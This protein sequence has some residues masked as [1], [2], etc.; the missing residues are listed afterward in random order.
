MVSYE[1]IIKVE[2]SFILH[3]HKTNL[4]LPKPLFRQHFGVTFFHFDLSIWNLSQNL[5]ILSMI[6]HFFC[7]PKVDFYT[8]SKYNL[9]QTYHGTHGSHVSF[10]SQPPALTSPMGSK[11]GSWKLRN[12]GRIKEPRCRFWCVS[13]KEAQNRRNNDDYRWWQLKYFWNFHPYLPGEMIQ[14]D[15]RIFFKWVGST[16]N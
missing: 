14:F 2:D 8:D 3:R 11:V 9:C 1:S 5:W 7:D 15:L 13:W 10:L 16:T 12:L 4:G 6:F